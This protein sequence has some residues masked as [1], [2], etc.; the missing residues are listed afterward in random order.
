MICLT[1]RRYSRSA[2]PTFRVRRP[3]GTARLSRCR[4]A[5]NSRRCTTNFAA[6]ATARRNSRTC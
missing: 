4:V 3:H 1:Y 2:I 6:A 5:H